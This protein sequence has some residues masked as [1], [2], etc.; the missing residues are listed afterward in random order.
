MSNFE[1]LVGALI[2]TSALA[3]RLWIVQRK[4][5]SK[6]RQNQAILDGITDSFFVLDQKGT[7][8]VV[9]RKAEQM[10]GRNR[11]NLIGR[12]LR[13]GLSSRQATE[14]D[15]RIERALADQTPSE[16]EQFSPTMNCWMEHQIYPIAD[17]GIVV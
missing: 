13:E 3:I 10:L 5:H 16:F 4:L 9:T 12:S 8:T 15:F 7:F 6:A 14:F 1:L 2:V 17:G 11:V